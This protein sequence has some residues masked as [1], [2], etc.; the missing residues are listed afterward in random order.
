MLVTSTIITSEIIGVE[1]CR[2]LPDIEGVTMLARLL[3]I[4]L[5]RDLSLELL[6]PR[7]FFLVDQVIGDIIIIEVAP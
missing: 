2:N 7:V 1:V 4:H 5:S 6:I 3:G